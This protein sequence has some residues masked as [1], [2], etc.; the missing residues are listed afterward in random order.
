MD[1]QTGYNLKPPIHEGRSG[2]RGLRAIIA[3]TFVLVSGPVDAQRQPVGDAGTT[4]GEFLRAIAPLDEPR[5]LCID[6]PGHRDRVRVQAP[7]VVHTCK[8]NI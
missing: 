8:W 6:I 3:F 1:A 5:G 4:R 7:L 2:F